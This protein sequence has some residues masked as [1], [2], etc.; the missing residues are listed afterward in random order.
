MDH[1]LVEVIASQVGIAIC[2][3]N[4]E[5][6]VAQLQDGDIECT[7]AQVVYCNLLF[8]LILAE[9]VGKGCGCRLVYYS[10]FL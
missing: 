9:S 8:F 3:L 10:L 2:G 6:A 4:L 5:N 7:A 1:F